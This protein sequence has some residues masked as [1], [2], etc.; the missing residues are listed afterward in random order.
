VETKSKTE[1]LLAKLARERTDKLDVRTKH[2]NNEHVLPSFAMLLIE[3]AL[4]HCM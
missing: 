1:T 4:P 3:S 2:P